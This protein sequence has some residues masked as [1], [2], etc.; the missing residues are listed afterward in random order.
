MAAST[1][2]DTWQPGIIS[3]ISSTS[4]CIYIYV[5][6]IEKPRSCR[7][8]VPGDGGFPSSCRSIILM[9]TLSAN[10]CSPTVAKVDFGTRRHTRIKKLIFQLKSPWTRTHI[11][12]HISYSFD[13]CKSKINDSRHLADLVFS[14]PH[15]D[16][17]HH[18]MEKVMSHPY[19]KRHRYFGIRALDVH[20]LAWKPAW[21]L[22]AQ[23]DN[24]SE[25][26][27]YLHK[28]LIK[29]PPMFRSEFWILKMPK[30][31]A[32]HMLGHRT[33]HEAKAEVSRICTRSSQV[34][35]LVCF[36]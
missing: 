15:E 27:Q 17:A 14:L 10:N 12:L 34:W 19:T 22:A 33:K 28:D 21:K 20:D 5:I 6:N 4:V 29:I 26:Q 8:V 2:D 11:L 35:F 7:H 18:C 13:I 31:L 36:W 32:K 16:L 23:R 25:Q 24:T 1:A 30:H 9:W 3:A